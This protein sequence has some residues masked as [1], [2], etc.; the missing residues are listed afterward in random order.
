MLRDSL[1]GLYLCA[2]I[3]KCTSE[4]LSFPRPSAAR[5]P[6]SDRRA[7]RGRVPK[8]SLHT[9][10]KGQFGLGTG[11]AMGKA[12][13]VIALKMPFLGRPWRKKRKVL[14]QTVPATPP[15]P[16]MSFWRPPVHNVPGLE[17]NWYE[18]VYRSHAAFCGCG[19]FINHI[20]NLATSLGRPPQPRPPGAPQPPPIR[21]LP[22][23]P[24]PEDPQPRRHNRTENQPWPGDG[25]GEGAAGDPVAAGEQEGGDE[26]GPEDVDQLLDMLDD[27][28]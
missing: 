11:R 17:R 27:A 5:R 23:L 15:E 21:P 10:V 22:A 20:N 8:V 16:H 4:W 19:D 2:N 7:S 14:L 9:G 25:G 12:L 3:S 24:A 13:R 6:R 1:P 18:S 28:E 26:Y